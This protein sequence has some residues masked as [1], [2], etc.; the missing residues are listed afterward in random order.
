MTGEDAPPCDYNLLNVSFGACDWQLWGYVD[1]SVI[2]LLHLHMNNGVDS[3]KH[4]S[5]SVSQ[6]NRNRRVEVGC[7]AFHSWAQSSSKYAH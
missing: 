4:K 5:I 7:P 2:E 3:E 1:P 6:M